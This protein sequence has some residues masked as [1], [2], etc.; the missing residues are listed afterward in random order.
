MMEFVPE[1]TAQAMT[2]AILVVLVYRR[3]RKR[4]PVRAGK[5]V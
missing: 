5:K 3:M 4:V 1:L 2:C